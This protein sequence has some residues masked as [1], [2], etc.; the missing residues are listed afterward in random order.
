M[1]IIRSAALAAAL[2]CLGTPAALAHHDDAE[3]VNLKVGLE[4]GGAPFL[5]GSFGP[6][7]E[8]TAD[9]T[10]VAFVR[11]RLPKVSPRTLELYVVDVHGIG[12]NVKNDDFHIG[13]LRLHL[14]DLGVFYAYGEPVTASR[15][16]RKWDLT[17][18][19]GADYAVSRKVTIVLDWRLFA[20]LDFARVLTSYGDYSR[21][22]GEEVLKGGQT[23][24][25]ISYCF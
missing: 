1:K 12:L 2:A 4:A 6:V 11:L 23:W 5:A 16:P 18:G 20:P 3:D 25:G 10:G 7:S 19:L 21:L 14:F 9:F 15:V 17:L 22:I 13:R 8:S 24:L